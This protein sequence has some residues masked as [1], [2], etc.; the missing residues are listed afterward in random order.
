VNVTRSEGCSSCGAELVA[1]ED[2][3]LSVILPAPMVEPIDTPAKPPPDSKPL[4]AEPAL[5]VFYRGTGSA[6][7]R[8]D[9]TTIDLDRFVSDDD[10]TMNG[11]GPRDGSAATVPLRCPGRSH[12]PGGTRPAL[13]GIPEPPMNE[14]VTQP[15]QP[16][17]VHE[18]ERGGPESGT[19]APAAPPA[20][21]PKLVVMRGMKINME[22][23]IYEG[24]NTIG[25]FADKPVDIDLIIQ[26]SVDQIWCS[27]QHAVITFAKGIVVI[28]DLNSLNGTWVN[29]GRVH[30]G[31]QRQLHAG[32]VIQIGTVQMRFVLA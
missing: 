1:I 11:H 23:P 5:T 18:P 24:R 15:P 3:P 17:T 29:G 10:A 6:T 26:E 16:L 19:P 27:R 8:A 14:V 2:I 22:Y 21:R 32:D 20:L 30:G 25:R 28:E 13:P 4:P 7:A 31:Q 12:S 9:A